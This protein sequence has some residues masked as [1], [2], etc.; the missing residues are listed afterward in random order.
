MLVTGVL[1]AS[2]ADN[3]QVCG[4]GQEAGWHGEKQRASSYLVWRRKMVFDKVKKIITDILNCDEDSI[5]M[6]TDLLKDLDA[7]SL[8]AVEIVMA[9]E[10]TYDIVVP[11]EDVPGLTV[12][13]NI[14]KYIE[15]H[16]E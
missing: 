4:P 5:T 15:T 9:V 11:D 7:D 16:I 10:D 8:D 6:E 1:Q 2:G 14:V 12:V 13:G 3:I